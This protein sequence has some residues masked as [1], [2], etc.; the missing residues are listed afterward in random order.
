MLVKLNFRF[1]E[2][3]FGML[4]AVAIFALGAAFWSSPNSSAPIQ[5]QSRAQT[6]EPS[7]KNKEEISWW[8]DPI[9]VFTLGLVFIGVLQAFIFYRQ[10][11]LIR[12][13]LGPAEKAANAAQD[14]A[15][16]ALLQ[17][18][19]A[20]G[21]ELSEIVFARFDLIWYPDAPP[22]QPDQIIPAGLIPR[23]E[24]RMLFHIKNS[25]RTRSRITELCAE[26]LLVDRT[27]PDRNPDPPEIPVYK[28][29]NPMSHIFGIEEMIPLK[30]SAGSDH[31]IRL[32][33]QQLRAINTNNT[34][35][36]IYGVCSYVDFMNDVYD[37]GF[38][39]HWEPIADIT[40]GATPLGVAR[41]FV[42]EGPGTYIYRRKQENRSA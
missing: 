23:N 33:E 15:T 5:Q 8:Q 40:L 31:V 27:S 26:W 19:A 21:A 6:A 17:A 13:S 24:M 25:G 42:S 9:A 22:G 16:A 4:L 30:W 20:V 2:I 18:R 38:C 1:P 41:G 39:A 37:V 28:N 7:T 12:R 3:V 29:R 11:V 10:M 35:L 14:T 32:T 34:W 36:W